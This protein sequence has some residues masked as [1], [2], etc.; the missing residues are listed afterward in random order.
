MSWGRIKH[1]SEMLS[2]DDVVEVKVIDYNTEKQ[3]VS[4]GIKQLES[5]PWEDIESK[6]P[7]D[8]VVKGRIVSITNYG[9]FVE[10]EKGVEGLIHISE[11]SWTQHIKHP[12]EIYQI[13][14][15]VEA[16]VLAIDSTDR[17]ISLGVKQ[18]QPDPWDE[19]EKKY[20]PG[21]KV[22]GI[23][24][25]LTQFGA[26]VEIEEGIDGLIHVSDLSW[27]KVVRHPKEIL[28]KG[29]EI[30]VVILEINNETRKISLGYKQLEE[31]PWEVLE[32][33]YKSNKM[34]KA[35]VL[36]VLDKGIIMTIEGEEVE[37]IVPLN[38]MSKKDKRDYTRGIKVGDELEL[39]VVEVRQ[40]DRK[41]VLASEDLGLSEEDKDVARVM[42]KQEDVTQKIEIPE[43][44][45]SKLKPETEKEAPA[46]AE[47]KADEPKAKKAEKEAKEEVEEKEAAPKKKSTK[48][49]E[50]KEEVAEEA[51]EAEEEAKEASTSAEA[52]AD[53]EEK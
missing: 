33:K 53:E 42:A 49:A 18:L 19:L 17:K 21:M 48:K 47:A 51:P 20:T 52:T 40:E 43:D 23:V 12:S 50:E 8:S 25:N 16:K 22:K 1:P 9:V 36:K 38:T 31:N 11:M 46:V 29:Q 15:E 27:I 34:V 14:D 37:A 32:N 10:L 26:F 5:H 44:L 2:I 7:I 28:Q 4:L 6:Y 45:L 41:I 39:R 24:R 30:D 13:N 3:R 35:T